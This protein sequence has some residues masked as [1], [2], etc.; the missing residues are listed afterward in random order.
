MEGMNLFAKKILNCT[1]KEKS[2][3]KSLKITNWIHTDAVYE[4]Y[5]VVP[6]KVSKFIFEILTKNNY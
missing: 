2:N 4:E 5:E 6:M 3:G 1:K